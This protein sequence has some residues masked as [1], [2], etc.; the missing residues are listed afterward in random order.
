[1]A[2]KRIEPQIVETWVP[3]LPTETQTPI[4][5]YLYDAIGIDH[6]VSLDAEIVTKLHDQQ[7]LWVDITGIAESELRALAALFSLKRESVY[8]LLQP[9]R[10]PRLDNYGTYFQMNIDAVEDQEGKYRLV[11]LNFIVGQNFVL[12][13]HKT[14]VQ[15][16]ESFDTRVKGD[17]QIGQLDAPAF[18]AALLDWHVT[19]FF[20][21]I[22]QLEAR[23][24]RLDTM[25]LRPRHGR[26]VLAE[27]AKLRQR[28]AFIRRTM[29]PHREVYAALARPDFQALSTSESASHYELLNDRLERAIEAVENARDL[30]I[31]S[32][33]MFTTQT[34]LRTNESMKTLTLVSVV[35]LPAN[36]ILGI[37]NFL[38]KSPVYPLGSGGFWLMI[39]IIV[40]LA[41]GTFG[42]VRW[43]RWV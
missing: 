13:V 34:A 24:D 17:T 19:S 36:V 7:L 16:L 39:A 15:F 4:R 23:V 11:E 35:L 43:R 28:V 14:A 8:S 5:A 10:R 21:V 25:A 41:V 32:F 2:T 29:T 6:V 37:S 27:L 38:I 31:G 18:L 42:L 20:R 12:T 40:I 3:R 22:E 1:M 30:L 26:D 33:D 9:E